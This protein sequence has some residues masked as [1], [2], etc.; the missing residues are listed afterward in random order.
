MTVSNAYN[1]PDQLSPA[2]REQILAAARELGY[3][4]PDPVARTLSSGRTGTVGMVFDEALPRAFTDPVS[5]EFLAGVAAGCEARELGLTLVPRVASGVKLIE[6]ALVDGF[7]LHC[8]PETDLRLAAVRGRQVPFVRIDYAPLEDTLDIGVDDRGAA[9][10]IAEHLVALGHRRF[11][12]VLPEDASGGPV[13]RD[14]LAA[15]AYNVTEARLLGWGDAVRAAGLDYE[16]MP[17]AIGDERDRAAG[18]RNVGALLDRADRPTAVL[19]FSDLLALDV[20][21]AA[22]QRGISVPG[23]LSI[24]GFDGIPAAADADP[25]LTTIV[26][27]HFAKGEQA[28]HLLLD[29]TEPQTVLLPTELVIRASTAPTPSR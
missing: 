10:E 4:G 13:V 16:A 9:R 26:Q 7:L 12:F 8:T 21:A 25:P 19:A 20:L 15:A 6:E 18:V 23:A 24:G 5:I 14:A 28:V 29:A 27:P 3:A 2:L 17:V 1:R 22:R 11:G